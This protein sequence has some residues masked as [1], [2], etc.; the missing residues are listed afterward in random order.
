MSVIQF[1]SIAGTVSS[2]S[3]NADILYLSGSATDYRFSQSGTSVI[4]SNGEQNATLRGLSLAQITTSNFVFNDTGSRLIIGDNNVATTDDALS[5][6]DLGPLDLVGTNSALLEKNNVLYGMGGAD[7]ISVGN[8]DNIIYGG[9]GESD[10]TDGG[11]RIVINGAGASSGT[12]RIF[13]NAGNDTVI[14][15]KPTGAGETAIVRMGLGEDNV[16]ISNAA[17]TVNVYGGRGNDTIDGTG[18]T[19]TLTILGNTTSADTVD[20]SDVL[21]SGLGNAAVHGNAG[22]DSIFFDDFGASASQTLTGGAGLDNIRGDIGGSGSTGRL[23]LYGN[24]GADTIDA[25]THLGN[26]TIYGGNGAGDSVD[27]ADLISIGTGNV[28]HH[29]FVYG[30]GGADTII[31]AANLAAGETL[32]LAGGVGTDTFSISGARAGSSGVTLDGATGNDTFIV[33]DS[34]LI[35]DA[36]TTFVNF[37]KTDIVQLTL[38]AGSA[39]T[40]EATNLGSSAIINNTA[41]AGFGTYVFTNYAGVFTATNLVLSDGSLFLSNVGSATAAALA[42]GANNDH[43]IASGKGDSITGGAGNDRL[44]GGDGADNINGNDGVETIFGGAGNDTIAAGDGGTDLDGIADSSVRGGEGS[45][46]ITGG[47]FEDSINGGLSNDTIIGGSGADTIAGGL[48]ADTFGYKVAEVSVTETLVDLVTDAF[49]GEAD[50]IDFTDL[51]VAS[52]RGTGVEFESGNGSSAQVL[53]AN[54]GVYVATN[55]AS[56]FSEADI[57]TAL[58]GI[59]DDLAANDMIYALISNGTDARL[60]RITESA[61][62]GSLSAV[63]DTLEYVARLQG[64]STGDLASLT[65]GNFADFA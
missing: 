63:D 59:A 57:Y 17:G 1:S 2:F 10:T 18:S 24:R 41:G 5:Q 39:I 35:A 37:E 27:A 19:G 48:G 65:E 58:S 8:G 29:A 61:N 42:G 52:L 22:D 9:T 62:P 50:V 64:V 31:S 49:T 45:D 46:S 60:V 43:I 34:T 15:T 55:L 40:L 28:N 6:T 14:F 44:L 7:T 3:A 54:A 16:L 4:V 13:A 26:V 51:S 33:N 25:T 47:A 38:N 32:M 20:G 23:T 21:T 36:A 30:N 56:T 11:D 53:S 12:N